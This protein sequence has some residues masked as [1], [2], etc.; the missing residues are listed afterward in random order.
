MTGRS[1]RRAPLTHRHHPVVS[2]EYFVAEANRVLALLLILGEALGG[3]SFRIEALF[4]L[5][6]H[7][8][9][10]IGAG[11]FAILGKVPTSSIS[12]RVGRRLTGNERGDQGNRRKRQK[13]IADARHGDL[14]TQL[15]K[16][17]CSP[18]AIEVNPRED[19]GTTFF[20]V[21]RSAFGE[22]AP[23]RSPSSS[24]P[25]L[26]PDELTIPPPALAAS[27]ALTTNTAIVARA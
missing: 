25:Y 15:G 7:R 17:P 14:Q 24:I 11:W 8:I 10:R 12:V 23:V 3:L 1:L 2:T 27:C 9:E 21:V 20:F 5:P 4:N 18:T 16:W 22:E 13:R 26:P 19:F 6:T